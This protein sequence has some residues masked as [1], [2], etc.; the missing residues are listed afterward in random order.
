MFSALL[1]RLNYAD[2]TV[3]GAVSTT[4]DTVRTAMNV[5]G[6]KESKEKLSSFFLLFV[7][8]LFIKERKHLFLQ[9]AVW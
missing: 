4:S 2:G 3:G 9:I 7:T 5:I 8:N 1:V 6:L